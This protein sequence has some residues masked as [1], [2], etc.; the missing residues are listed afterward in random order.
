MTAQAQGGNDSLSAP[1]TGL[2]GPPVSIAMYGDGKTIDG[3]VIC[4]SD[5]F[6]GTSVLLSDYSENPI[7]L[8]LYGDG[9]SLGGHS[10]GGDDVLIGGRE[11]DLMWGDAATVAATAGTG[12]DRFALSPLN[13]HDEIM[14]YQPGKDVI[15]LTG[16]GFANF[17]D[18]S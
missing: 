3:Q 13:G 1:I 10:Q 2:Y 9:E 12:A 16:F 18:L 6:S 4:G 14:D 17:Q 5:T 7:T 11:V 15:A 8:L